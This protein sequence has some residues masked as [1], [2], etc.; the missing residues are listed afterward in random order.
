[1]N[2]NKLS[3]VRGLILRITLC[4]FLLFAL[5]GGSGS[6]IALLPFVGS[7][8]DA[9]IRHPMELFV[10]SV[11]I[12]LFH[13]TG[14]AANL[15]VQSGSDSALHWIAVLVI[16]ASGLVSGLLWSFVDLRRPDRDLLGWLRLSRP[17]HP[18]RSATPLRVHQDFSQSSSPHRLSPF[19]TKRSVRHR[20]RCSSGRSTASGRVS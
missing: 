11:S 10:Q 5:F 16:F 4:F 15:H 18:R 1:M 13:L 20:R 6:L 8:A 12:H 9:A 7:V 17:P 3:V 19:S 14:P 2:L